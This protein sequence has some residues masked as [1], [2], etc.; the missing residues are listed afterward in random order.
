M[1]RPTALKA[2]KPRGNKDADV[3]KAVGRPKKV[4]AVVEAAESDAAPDA[5]LVN[6]LDQPPSGAMTM[7]E[8]RK[9]ARS[10]ARLS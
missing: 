9:I 8:V 6:P 4:P 7:D 3:K 2:L 1:A 5:V 10:V